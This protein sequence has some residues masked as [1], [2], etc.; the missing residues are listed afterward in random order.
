MYK[1]RFFILWAPVP[2]TAEQYANVN[3]KSRYNGAITGG[4]KFAEAK[5]DTA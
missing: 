1:N 4:T 3:Y 5:I 2:E